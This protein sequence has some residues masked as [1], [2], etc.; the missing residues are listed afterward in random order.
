MAAKT[1]TLD[2]Q[3]IPMYKATQQQRYLERGIRKWKQQAS[4]LETAGLENTFEN[5]KVREWQA[6]MR[7]FTSQTGLSRQYPR[8]QI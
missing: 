7:D 1:V 4:A 5:A 2:G 6:R 8:E 3:T